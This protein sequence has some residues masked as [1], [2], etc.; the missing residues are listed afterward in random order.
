M[1]YI[2][3]QRDGTTTVAMGKKTDI[4]I[5][6]M[7]LAALEEENAALLFEQLTGEVFGDV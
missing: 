1:G 6:N 4:E 5:L 2:K 7:Q 3:L